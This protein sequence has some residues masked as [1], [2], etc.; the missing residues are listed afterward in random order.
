MEQ[1]PS[2]VGIALAALTGILWVAVA[3]VIYTGVAVGI[4]R[5]WGKRSLWAFWALSAATLSVLGVVRLSSRY[6][7]A[8]GRPLDWRW[9]SVLVAFITLATAGACL[10]I[11]QVGGRP[12]RPSVARQTL[13]GCLGMA[14]VGGA[15]VMAF[16]VMDARRLFQP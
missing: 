10:R 5:Q 6:V 4:Q 8:G 9:G 2:Q 7:S 15:L 3:A 1:H 16:L 13:A 14:V 12:S 11:A